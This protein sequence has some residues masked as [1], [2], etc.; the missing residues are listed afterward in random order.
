MGIQSVIRWFLPREDKFYD[1]LER[2]AVIAHEGAQALAR[3]GTPSGGTSEAVSQ[4]VQG[5]EHQ[6]D[7]VVHEMEEALATTFVTPLDR[8]DLQKLSSELDDVL[9]LMNG[10]AR[11]AALYGVDQP[12]EAMS[13][14]M[15]H[16]VRSTALLASGLP[17]LRAHKYAELIDCARELRRIE[18]DADAVFREAISRLFHDPAAVDARYVLRNR[19]VLEDLEMAID[20]CEHVGATLK[21]LA[22]K[23][24]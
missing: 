19:I 20:H 8:E 1:F 24:G 16:L 17:K 3:F 15:Q 2:Q 14:L 5:F 10:A 6:G 7:A 23:H 22:V 11:G 13:A 9:D 18:K 21:Y 12:T 4:V